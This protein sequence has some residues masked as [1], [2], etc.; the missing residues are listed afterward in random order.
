MSRGGIGFLIGFNL[1]PSKISRKNKKYLVKFN[2]ELEEINKGIIFKEFGIILRPTTK[3]DEEKLKQF[4][5]EIQSYKYTAI[6][7]IGKFVIEEIDHLKSSVYLGL[8]HFLLGLRILKKGY[9][10]LSQILGVDSIWSI[11]LPTIQ[12]PPLPGLPRPEYELYYNEIDNLKRVLENINE[13]YLQ[14]KIRL[15]IALS[16]FD[17]IYGLTLVMDYMDVFINLMICSEALFIDD[18]HFGNIGTIIGLGC[19]MLI[20]KNRE[21]RNKIKT[22]FKDA[23]SIRNK[24]IH[25]GDLLSLNKRALNKFK[26]LKS[27]NE[28]IAEYLRRAFQKLLA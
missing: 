8:P 28:N 6:P 3:E 25:G 19:S 15:Q 20:G 16:Y 27:L 24:I 13:I 2:R 17:K 7:D 22:D 26:N 14:K 4:L 12:R 18:K 1:I 10:Y 23:Y 21:E 5:P 9:V 11:P